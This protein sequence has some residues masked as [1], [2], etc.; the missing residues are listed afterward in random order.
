M[1]DT[2]AD[3]GDVEIAVTDTGVGM[4]AGPRQSF[5]RFFTTKGPKG[6]GLG[7][8]MT[9]G[10]L[11]RHGGRITVDSEEGRAA[12]QP[13]GGPPHARQGRLLYAGQSFWHAADEVCDR[14]RRRLGVSYRAGALWKLD[15]A[16]RKRGAAARGPSPICGRSRSAS[17]VLDAGRRVPALDRRRRGFALD[18]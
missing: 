14:L 3:D 15:D 6:T 12:H 4:P 5:H 17:L 11:A 1:H 16:R 10:I 2:A 9:F 13:H 18:V 8:S 7:L